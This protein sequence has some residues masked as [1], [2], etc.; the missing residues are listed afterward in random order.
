M[1]PRY[2]QNRIIM[3][4]IPVPTLIYMCEIY[5]SRISLAA[6]K[7][8]DGSWEYINR[9]Q[10]HECEN[11]DWGHAIARKGIHKWNFPCSVPCREEKQLILI[12]SPPWPLHVGRRIK[13]WSVAS[14]SRR[15]WCPSWRPPW[16]IWRSS[17]TTQACHEN[18]KT[19]SC[20]LYS[21]MH[22]FV[23]LLI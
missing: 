20:I 10:T 11:W 16:R 7:Y 4:C 12:S 1:Q 14:N 18:L 19:V 15:I 17:S 9:S 2:F 22:P 8:V 5:I 21:Y 13:D 6:A 3:L 23:C